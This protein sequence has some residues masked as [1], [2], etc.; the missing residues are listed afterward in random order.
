MTHPDRA[1]GGLLALAD[2]ERA[3]RTAMPRAVWDF[4]QGGSGEERSLVANRAALDARYLVPRVL[5]DVSRVSTAAPL[6]GEAAAMPVAVAPMAYQRLVH[7]AGEVASAEAARRAGVPFVVPLLSSVPVEEI[8]ETGAALWF[9]MYP[10]RDREAM[11]GVLA[12]AEAAGCRALVLTVDVPRMGRRLR[13]MR[14]SFALPPGVG[15]AHLGEPA[16]ETTRRRRVGM[17]AVARHTREAFDPALRWEDLEWLR[18]QTGMPL[19]LKGVLHPEDARRAAASGVQGLIVSNHGGRQ[20]DGAVPGFE[21]LPA[22]REA[23]PPGIAVLYDGG[24]R[25]GADVLRALARGAS[26]VLLGRPVLWGLAVGGRRGVEHVLSLL[27]QELDDAMALAGCR[28]VG[29]AAELVLSEIPRG[30]QHRR[31]ASG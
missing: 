30:G 19:I 20:L 4:V 11:S 5:R 16:G 13:D 15:A 22:I 24:V 26:G 17:S 14:N 9:Q 2:V 12:R 29:E 27:R 21:A 28:D 7:P 10:L 23:T 18:E 8:A 25:S 1:L 3:A 6:A 31:T